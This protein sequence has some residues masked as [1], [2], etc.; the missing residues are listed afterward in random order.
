MNKLQA[1][2][3][4]MML[5]SEAG[6]NPKS[7]EYRTLRRLIAF[8]IDRLGPD[9]ALEQIRRDKDELLAQMKLILF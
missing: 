9:A 6:L 1:M 7:K 8:K 5:F 4:S 2:A 3:R